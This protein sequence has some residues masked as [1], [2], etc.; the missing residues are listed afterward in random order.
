MT[1]ATVINTDGL[2]TLSLPRG[3]NLAI[4]PVVL[5]AWLDASCGHVRILRTF[6]LCHPV[7]LP[8]TLRLRAV[9]LL[10]QRVANRF[11]HFKLMSAPRGR[12]PN[13]SLAS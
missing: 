13:M 7:I 12:I 9:S 10:M 4:M 1:T 3:R 8:A 5:A 2:G 11:A 6:V